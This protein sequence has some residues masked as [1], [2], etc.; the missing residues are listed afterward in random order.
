MTQFA[1]LIRSWPQWAHHQ[2]AARY[3]KLVFN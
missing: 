1:G 2:H 3:T